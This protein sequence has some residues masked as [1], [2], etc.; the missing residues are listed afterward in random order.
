MWEDAHR[1]AQN[2]GGP[3][4]AKQVCFSIS[5]QYFHFYLNL[6]LCFCVYR[7]SVAY[8]SNRLSFCQFVHLSKHPFVCLS[9]FV[10][11]LVCHCLFLIRLQMLGFPIKKA[12]LQVYHYTIDLQKF[13]IQVNVRFFIYLNVNLSYFPCRYH[14]RLF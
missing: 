3:N 10:Y 14:S 13:K 1:V 2:N 4:A 6:I 11:L 9:L 12:P 7:L 8:P 5:F